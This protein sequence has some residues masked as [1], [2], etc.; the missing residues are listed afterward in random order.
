MFENNDLDCENTDQSTDVVHRRRV[1]V[2]VSKVTRQKAVVRNSSQRVNAVQAPMTFLVC[3][4]LRPA[5][6]V[7][8]SRER[9]PC[10][11]VQHL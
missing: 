8:P 4:V 2:R 9:V 10:R 7:A 3:A 6:A 1:L 5:W 11:S